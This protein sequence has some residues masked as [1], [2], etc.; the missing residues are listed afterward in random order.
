MYAMLFDKDRNFVWSHVPDPVRKA[1]EVLLRIEAAAVNRADLIQRFGNYPPPPGWPEWC[2]LEAAG[3]VLEAPAGAAVKPGDKV[4]ALLGGGGYAEM[5]AVPAGMVVPV[6]QGLS[7]EE[8]ATLP[9]V[10]CT[11]YLNLQM[12]A[13]GLKPG[14]VVYLQAAASGVGLAAIQFA[15]LR[16]AEVIAS[17]GTPEKADFV[18]ALGAQYVVNYRTDDVRPVLEAHPPTVALDCIGGRKMGECLRTMAFGGR[19][20]MIASLGGGETALD[21]EMVWRKRLRIIGS[22]LRSRTPEEKREILQALQREL[23]P[24]FSDR[25]IRTHIHKSFP[26]QEAGAAHAVLQQAENIGKVVLTLP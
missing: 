23:W 9:E 15:R 16:G 6:P 12:E 26:M 2:G 8:A 5:V 11:V 18:R 19:W 3:T 20:I 17:V 14:D 21:L 1:D 10:W 25:S 24:R 13:G 7:M 4:C 22:T